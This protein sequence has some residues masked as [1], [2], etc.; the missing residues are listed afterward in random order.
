MDY[1][2]IMLSSQEYP[3]PM[4]TPW[5]VDDLPDLRR[6]NLDEGLDA[7]CCLDFCGYEPD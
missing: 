3:D 1:L 2:T 7:Y 4:M 5:T 6:S